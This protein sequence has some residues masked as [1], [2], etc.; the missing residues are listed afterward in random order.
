MEDFI[1][2]YSYG[3]LQGYKTYGYANSKMRESYAYGFLQDYKT[4]K[5]LSSV[6]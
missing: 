5:V 2:S 3:F 6:L 4:S 1:V